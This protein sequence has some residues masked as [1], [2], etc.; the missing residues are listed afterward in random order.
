MQGKFSTVMYFEKLNKEGKMHAIE[1]EATSHQHTIRL[2]LATL[3]FNK[4]PQHG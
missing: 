4:E 2:Y 1:F 3:D